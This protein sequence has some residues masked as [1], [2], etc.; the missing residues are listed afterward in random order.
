MADNE[1]WE[2]QLSDSILGVMFRGA[3]KNGR[4]P[5]LG[6]SGLPQA[7]KDFLNLEV[8][9]GAAH[10]VILADFKGKRLIDLVE[11]VNEAQS[12]RITMGRGAKAGQA[13][14]WFEV[15]KP[16]AKRK[17]PTVPRGV[18]AIRN[19][20]D[21]MRYW[22]VDEVTDLNH[23]VYKST[24]AGA[25][26]SVQTPDGEWHHNGQDWTGIDEI[27][28]FTIQTIVEGSDAEV[29]S[30]EFVLPVSTSHVDEWISD[31]ESEADRLWHEANE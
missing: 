21:L 2:A 5:S 16:P 17:K 6:Y 9:A 20:N 28:A 11:M 19:L 10:N 23:R 4:G 13:T 26:I 18:P 27:I 14:L 31:M 25:S 15:P 7:V 12:G 8:Q 22:N 3:R 1:T 30:D 24:D 29:N